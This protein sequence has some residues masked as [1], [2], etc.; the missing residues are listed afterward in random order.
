M[1]SIVN[2]LFETGMLKKTPRSG[3][4]FLGSGCESVAEHILSTLFIAYTLC[5]LEKDVD[6]LKVLRI[7][8]MHDLPEARTG[9]M[10]YVNKKYVTVDEEKAVRELTAPLSFGD[11]I[12]DAITEFNEMATKESLI[13]H[14]ADQLSLILELKEHGDLGNKYSAEWIEFARKRLVTES[15]KNIADMIIDTDSTE[16]WFKDKSDWWINGNRK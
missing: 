8:L 12:K 1:K 13:A 7:C 15:A 11:E 5:K 6:E 16:W 4:Q 14:D 2:L 3:F 9:D 10:N